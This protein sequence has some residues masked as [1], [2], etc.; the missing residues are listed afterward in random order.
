MY[1]YMYIYILYVYIYICI[2]TYVN[3]YDTY[4]HKKLKKRVTYTKK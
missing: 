1:I 2:C 3:T 4:I